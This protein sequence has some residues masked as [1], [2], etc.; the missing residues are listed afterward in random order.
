VTDL[1]GADVLT[2]HS[3][4]D[5]EMPRPRPLEVTDDPAG[6]FRL[7]AGRSYVHFSR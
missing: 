3:T 1:G 6:G 7:Y 2:A 4:K 5:S